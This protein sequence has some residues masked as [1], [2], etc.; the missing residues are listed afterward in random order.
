M[1][2]PLRIQ[3]PGAVNHVTHRGNERRNIYSDDGDRHT[4]L[5]ILQSGQETYTVILHCYVL[6]DNHF[7]LLVETPLGNLAEFMRYL[8]ITYTSYFNRT[9]R[10]SGHLYQGRYK[11]YLIEKESYLSSVSRYIHLNPAR[12]KSIRQKSTGEQLRYLFSYR[13][14]SLPGF[15]NLTKR[16]DIVNYG[17]I[18]E[19]FGGDT[20]GGRAAYKKQIALDLTEGKVIPESII[21]K[22]ILGTDQFISMVREKYLPAKKDRE[23]PAIGKILSYVGENKIIAIIADAAKV[24]REELLT[25]PGVMRQITM[26]MLYR[27]GGLT[28]PRIGELMGIDYSTVS[29]GRKRLRHRA[30]TDADIAMLL[31]KVNSLCQG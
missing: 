26:D 14:S 16:V 20:A 15:A 1:A 11:S 7:H 31:E 24:S 10:R 23:R 30:K 25:T 9:H 4:F 5:K 8:N 12:I 2:R 27:H 3:Y 22:S 19:R 6:M 28:N 18:L 21:G 29:Q 13:W 17:Y